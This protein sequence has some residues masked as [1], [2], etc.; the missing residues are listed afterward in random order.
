MTNRVS[1]KEQSDNL[2]SHRTRKKAFIVLC[3][4]VLHFPT[5]CGSSV[6]ALSARVA[7]ILNRDIHEP[8][9]ISL[10][11]LICSLTVISKTTIKKTK[12]KTMK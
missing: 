12:K 2:L 9:R 10:T 3:Y 5:P 8:Q 11:T 4:F 6:S 7:N 1:P